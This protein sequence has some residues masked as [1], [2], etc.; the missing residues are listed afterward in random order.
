MAIYL[1]DLVDNPNLL[2]DLWAK[3]PPK[4]HTGKVDCCEDCYYEEFGNFIEN[5]PI[6]SIGIRRS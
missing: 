6:T 1:S 3:Q 5:N 4:E 2:D